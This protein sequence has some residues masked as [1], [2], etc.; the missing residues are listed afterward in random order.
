MK[1]Y[2]PTNSSRSS[3]CA[4]L[5]L[6]AAA[7]IGATS[8]L[9]GQASGSKVLPHHVP[10]A[11]AHSKATGLLSPTERLRLAVGMPLRD[12]NGLDAFLA[13]VYD[14][15]SPNYRQFLTPEQFTERFGPTTQDYQA[16][17]EFVQT[18]GLNVVAT[19]G[20]RLLCDVTGSVADIQRAFHITLR[21]Y[22][23][24]AEAR[25]FF[26]TD[27]EP[28]VE[29][30]LP[31]SDISGLDNYSRPHPT[32]L[33]LVRSGSGSGPVPLTGL[34]SGPGG[35]YLGRDLRAAYLSDVTL[36]GA[37]QMVGLLEFDGF[38][39]GDITAYVA[40]AG[41]PAVPIQTVLLDGFD[42]APTPGPYSGSQEV[43]LDIEMAMA[44]AP[45]LSGIVVFEAGPAGIV[46]DALN[47]MAASN[48]VKQLSCSWGWQG[49]P[50]ATRDNIFK[51]MAAQGQSF[52]AA[53]GDSDA[54]TTGADS[55][56]GVDNPMLGNAPSSC[57]YITIVGGTTLST[58]GPT[59]SWSS[60]TVWN[61]GSHM[62]QYVGSSGGISSYYPLPGWQGGIDMTANGGSASQR[63]LPDVALT[64]DNVYAT[65]GN[66]S[67]GA[68]SG[69]SCAAPL[70][71]GVAA[72]INQQAVAAGR[73]TVG[74][75]NPAIYAIGKG[76]AYAS[77]FHDIVAGN[78]CSGSS[79]GL[80]NA[81]AG[82][83]LCTGWGTPAGQ[84]LIDSLAGAANPL[85]ITPAGGFTCSGPVG[86]PFQPVSGS[87]WLTNAG[88]AP[89]TWSLVN[90]S[91]WLKVSANGG[92]LAAGKASQ[93]SANLTAAACRLPPGT[94]DASLVVNNNSGGAFTVTVT[95]TAGQSMVENGGFET[96]DFS[97][98][99][100]Q[101]N[102]IIYDTIYNAVEGLG[103]G[104][105]V[106]YSGNYGA[107]LGDGQLASLSQTL[108]TVPGQ[109]YL[110]SLWL[111][112][113]T[114]GAGQQFRLNWNTNAL[115]TT[116]LF[117]IASPPAFGW[118]NLQFLV[119]SAG[120]NT[121][122]QLQAENDASY[123][124]VDDINV[125]PVPTPTF[126]TWTANGSDFQLTWFT[127]AGLT[128]QV[129]Y[130]TDLAQPGWIDL[131]DPFLAT[132]YLSSWVDTNAIRSAP[133]RYYR[134][135]ICLP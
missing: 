4:A 7:F 122:L 5:G 53:S 60:E 39:S 47:A 134:I 51:Q 82:Y 14:P 17:V 107:F 108:A 112:N 96:G 93:V 64:A 117:S 88:T 44:I 119:L 125:T 100:L 50:S 118:T 101:G 126:R 30:R 87:F 91:S 29:A 73:G 84:A 130:K 10:A 9:A 109:L 83:D 74:F 28:S 56:N 79:P 105:D 6:A 61:A 25:D 31:I 8:A 128:Y 22:R 97:G 69:T 85:S 67:S 129:Q 116:T 26:A 75:L 36:T 95:L 19:H 132:D 131:G 92:T 45:G 11:V 72:L 76:A 13:R 86:G 66:G 34:G 3:R 55:V 57:P 104:F 115:A 16:V 111:D 42:G 81:T 127:T 133:H 37:G 124:G 99:T 80:F 62:G 58:T 21:T 35:G 49:G 1:S 46:N 98:W 18:N 15:A 48:Q 106:I 68:L 113:P 102:T 65:G 24:P 38:Y 40:A 121:T 110:L 120:T 12:A 52:F 41:Q 32:S 23:H 89:L 27:T 77:S 71:A 20:N 59:G 135:A 78:N 103:S 2:L 43:S 94:Y 123:F 70:W 63:N 33:K 90:T 114:K 54:Y